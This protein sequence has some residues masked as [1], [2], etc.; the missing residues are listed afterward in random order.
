MFVADVQE[1]TTSGL[2]GSPPD[3]TNRKAEKGKKSEI[4]SWMTNLR[5]EEDEFEKN[6]LCWIWN[7]FENPYLN[8][9]HIHDLSELMFFKV[10]SVLQL[11]HLAAVG[12]RQKTLTGY[13]LRTPIVSLVS[14]AVRPERKAKTAA[15]RIHGAKSDD[16]AAMVEFTFLKDGNILLISS[17][18]SWI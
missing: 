8:A 5:G 17:T 1:A 9:S 13:C 12:G 6:Q 2:S 18:S 14:N 4:G 11:G 7:Y 15:P 10:T 3:T 16:Q